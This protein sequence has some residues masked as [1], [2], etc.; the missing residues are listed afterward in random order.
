[1]GQR[2]NV[3]NVHQEQ[4][5]D[6]KRCEGGGGSWNEPFRIH[7]PW[8]IEMNNTE[9]RFKHEGVWYIAVEE[10]SCRCCAFRDH[11]DCASPDPHEG[12][13]PHCGGS[14]RKDNRS[15]IFVKS[16]ADNFGG[17]E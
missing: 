11:E 16:D 8:R 7:S 9:N 6:K 14:G 10:I 17:E 5:G 13:V 12:N 4:R 2:K 15:V 1:M 3:Q